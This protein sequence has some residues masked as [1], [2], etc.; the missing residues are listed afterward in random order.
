MYVS[1]Q[2]AE[3]QMQLE[4]YKNTAVAVNLA[5]YA[6]TLDRDSVDHVA[7]EKALATI[8]DVNENTV[9]GRI[10]LKPHKYSDTL[11]HFGTYLYR[12]SSNGFIYLPNYGECTD[13]FNEDWY[14][15]GIA[16]DG[17]PAWST[18]YYDPYSAVAMIT[19]SVPFF[20]DTGR[21][22]GIGAADMNIVNIRRITENTTVGK[23]GR[24]LIIGSRGEYM[25]LFGGERS[26]G[27]T[28][29][30]DEDA[31]LSQLG[32]E[33][34]QNNEGITTLKRNG[35]HYRVYYSKIGVV[36][37]TMA[38]MVDKVEIHS[39]AI[40]ALVFTTFIPIVGIL[41]IIAGIF[42]FSSNLRNIIG[43][44]NSVVDNAASGDFS[45]RV[46]VTEINEFGFMEERI[47]TM[48]SSLDEMSKRSA[49]LLSATEQANR[50]KSEF[51]S[52]MSHE[53]RSPMNAIIGMTQIAK[54]A[55]DP[56]RV[57]HCL[58]KIDNASKHLLAII[59]DVL[60]MSKIEANKLELVS[61]EFSIE[62]AIVRVYDMMSVKAEEKEQELR[63]NVDKTIPK[64]VIG[65]ELR[66]S[67]VI[68]NLVSNAIK[69]TPVGGRI[70]I[71]AFEI[72]SNGDKHTIRVDVRDNGIGM[73]LEQIKKL[74]EPFE[75]GDGSISRKFGGTGLGL[76]ISKRLV[77]MMGGKI[78]L[79]SGLGRGSVFSFTA[80]VMVG[81][82][83]PDEEGAGETSDQK[84]KRSIR[85]KNACI[86]V[87]DDI[88]IN[89]EI[90]AEYLRD[91]ATS[92]DFAMNGAETVKKFLD[93]PY[94]YDLILMD[95]QMPEMDGLEATRRIRQADVKRAKSIPIIAMTAN[96]L[97][98]DVRK[99][100]EAGMNDHVAKPVDFELLLQ[101]LNVHL[102]N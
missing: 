14:L 37:W 44:V 3:L 11:H 51:L 84:V 92:I 75:Q 100:M 4:L 27:N 19:V 8:I 88:E 48:I 76:T 71:V 83:V 35:R 42:A 29:Q 67:Q 33:M 36:D 46:E 66:F 32:R 56:E 62:D 13:F 99:C 45:K 7:N 57:S 90:V 101:K 47:N 82:E 24:A 69:F 6:K 98:E 86:L 94:R 55:D 28:I 70:D 50:S 22:A 12:D 41:M 81:A 91:T 61:E 68:T 93:N 95:I 21:F 18:V 39:S 16:S 96:A 85:E 49:E 77:E 60:D 30:D 43:K 26:I 10:W 54:A 5:Y 2:A 31:A 73:T 89:R 53:I 79:E 74:F 15:K 64:R 59:N 1:L 97:S 87:A 20:D 78:W 34:L 72:D 102:S 80:E 38:V 63:F 23:T 9:G 58:T 25:T 40:R 65:D 17:K 52:R